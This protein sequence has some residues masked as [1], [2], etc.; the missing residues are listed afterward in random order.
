[1]DMEHLNWFDLFISDEM[2]VNGNSWVEEVAHVEGENWI[3]KIFDDPGRSIG[4]EANET[5]YDK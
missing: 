4:F 2:D 1:M 3:V 5:Y